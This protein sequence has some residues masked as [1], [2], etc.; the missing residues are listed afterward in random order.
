MS[1]KEIVAENLRELRVEIQE[2]AKDL[3][4]IAQCVDIMKRIINKPVE[5]T[6][7]Y[8]KFTRAQLNAMNELISSMQTLVR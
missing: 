1:S 4:Q 7:D 8:A 6:D 2:Q 3:G 5:V